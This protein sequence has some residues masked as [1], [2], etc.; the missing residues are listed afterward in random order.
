MP[1]YIQWR[2]NENT[3]SFLVIFHFFDDLRRENLRIKK[4]TGIWETLHPQKEAWMT[5]APTHVEIGLLADLLLYAN[6][7][8][9]LSVPEKEKL[10]TKLLSMEEI[11]FTDLKA[12]WTHDSKTDED[13]ILV[14]L[15]PQYI[16]YLRK[17]LKPYISKP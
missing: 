11:A 1:I 12:Y 13:I 16:E 14:E 5:W 7:I 8:N 4:K 9:G 6:I 10:R 17:L 15:N 2:W 3:K